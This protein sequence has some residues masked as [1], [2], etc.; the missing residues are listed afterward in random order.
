MKQQTLAWLAELPDESA[1]WSDLYVEARMLRDIAIAEADVREGRE[2]S[3]S[4]VKA[5]LDAC[6]TSIQ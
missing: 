1:V 3:L 5:R 6:N 4:E 2:S